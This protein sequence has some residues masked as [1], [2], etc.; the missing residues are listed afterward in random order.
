MPRTCSI[1][2]DEQREEIDAALSSGT[3]LRDI[4]GQYQVGKSSLS[5]HKA[6]LR[7]SGESTS[8]Q[9]TVSRRAQPTPMQMEFIRGIREGKSYRQ[10][11]LSAGYSEQIAKQA[12]R[13]IIPSIRA[14][15][16]KELKRQFDSKRY[17]SGI[18]RGTEAT[19]TQFFSHEGIVT[20]QR[21]VVDWRV[22]IRFLDL[23]ADMLGSKIQRQQ[24]EG[25]AGGPM[26]L[27][28]AVVHIGSGSDP[29]E[30]PASDTNSPRT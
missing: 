13:K 27:Q 18:L 11:A 5:R 8:G 25:P 14:R 1:C 6:H 9:R 17:V 28:V 21:E 20:D 3:S 22:R 4:A 30:F 23:L 12:H 19:V 29:V 10:A 24:I 7:Q 15:V 2:R 16:E 26:Q